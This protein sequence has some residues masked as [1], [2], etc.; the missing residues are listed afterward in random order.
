MG[1]DNSN[2][3]LDIIAEAPET[4]SGITSDAMIAYIKSDYNTGWMNGDIKLA[5]LSDTDDTN[6][7]G[8][9]LVTN[10]TFDTNTSGWSTSNAT[11]SVSSGA[12][13]ISTSTTGYGYAYQGITGLTVGKVYTATLNKLY[14]NA[15]T[16]VRLGTAFDSQTYYGTTPSNGIINVTFT[17][18]S[19]T[20]YITLV[21]GAGSI[22]LDTSFDD[23]SVRLAEE[24]RSV[25]GNGLQV[26]GTVTKTAV[27]TG[28][29]LVGYRGNGYLFQPQ[30]GGLNL[31]NDLSITW[32]QK[33]NGG[34]IYE[35]WQ[36]AENST[37]GASAYNKV[38][39]SI[40]HQVSSS[41]Y[42][43]RGNG[44][45]GFA[46][47]SN[48]T[49]TGSWQC[50]CFTKVGTTYSVYLNGVLTRLATESN[51]TTPSNPYSLQLLR[52]QYGTTVYA[53]G[54][55]EL[56]LFRT[57]STVPSPEQIKK[58]YEDEKHLFQ[59]NAKATLYGSSDAVTALAY[60][61]DTEL[62]HVGGP[63]GR[64]VFQGLRRVDNT[65]DAVGAA[66]SASN[67][68]VAED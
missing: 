17:A 30:A 40:M 53:T 15:A 64:S 48:T 56:A 68:M 43:I 46:T 66:I 67:G 41:E 11:L 16:W 23:I 7:T 51:I 19:S 38:A 20:L 65:T 18:T 49:T 1:G 57:S 35:G 3:G 63:N 45:S 12:L 36:I 37:S 55:S 47:G 34:G 28:A 42:L 27:A 58:I 33:H 9:E 60:D 24:D 26:F 59:E 52:W 8:S 10:G 44:L 32:W 61:D 50:V 25:N 22:G 2:Y 6:V 31:T 4:V 39:L 62:L 54:N 21:I 5:T 13:V 14:S 29:D